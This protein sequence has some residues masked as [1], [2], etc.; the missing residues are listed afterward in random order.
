MTPSTRCSVEQLP[1]NDMRVGIVV[2]IVKVVR[3]AC[4][5]CCYAPGW[6]LL[7]LSW[8]Y[9]WCCGVVLLVVSDDD[10][11]P[12]PV[13]QLICLKLLKIRRVEERQQRKAAIAD[14]NL[15]NPHSMGGTATPPCASDHGFG[16][17]SFLCS[18][19]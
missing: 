4:A 9:W 3:S 10:G 13:R 7:F 1:D 6:F 16:Q 15:P 12:T 11:D 5:G 14:T 19:Q 2:V 8:C 18:P 17:H